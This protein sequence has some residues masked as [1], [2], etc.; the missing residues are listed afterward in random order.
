MVDKKT[1][2]ATKQCIAGRTLH[3][4]DFVVVRSAV[5][6]TDQYQYR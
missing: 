6:S 4:T 1:G 2:L 5:R 3:S